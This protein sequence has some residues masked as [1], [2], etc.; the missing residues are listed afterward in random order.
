MSL[1][2]KLFHFVLLI[3]N[4]YGIDDSHGISHSMNTLH[5]ANE[6]FKDE[7]QRHP[8]LKEQEKLIYTTAILHDMCDKKYMNEYVGLCEIANFLEDDALF[9]PNEINIAC[10]I[11]S[12]MSYSKVKRDGFP[13]LGG[14]QR[15]YNIVRESDLLTAY[16]FDRCLIYNMNRNDCDLETSFTTANELFEHRVFKHN[17]DKLFLLDYSKKESLKLETQSLARINHWKQV[18]RTLRK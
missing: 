15:A 16:D 1:I 3:T 6:I 10:N 7:V 18:I 11:M 17:D 9:T 8:I 2:S 14:Y 4:K 12:T 13:N 5:Y